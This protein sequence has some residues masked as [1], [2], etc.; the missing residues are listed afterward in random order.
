MGAGSSVVKGES[1][2]D[3]VWS[4][5]SRLLRTTSTTG[6]FWDQLE[7]IRGLKDS[8]KQLDENARK[9]QLIEMGMDPDRVESLLDQTSRTS[10]LSEMKQQAPESGVG[11]WGRAKLLPT[12]RAWEA[13]FGA[14]EVGR[15]KADER[16]RELVKAANR[17]YMEAA[18]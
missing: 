16:I 14:S 13:D 2:K 10:R 1:Q 3:P 15:R 18:K 17:K 6:R 5:S 8:A 11:L 9:D 4:I 7:E 12:E